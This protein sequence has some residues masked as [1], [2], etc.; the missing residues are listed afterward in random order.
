MAEKAIS[1]TQSDYRAKS[2][3]EN[4]SRFEGYVGIDRA[5]LSAAGVFDH[6][7]NANAPRLIDPMLPSTAARLRL[8]RPLGNPKSELQSE[9]VLARRQT[10]HRIVTPVMA[11]HPISDE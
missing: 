5:Q 2:S 4:F 6:T 3:K 11:A 10:D 8:V 9:R 1:I 7:L